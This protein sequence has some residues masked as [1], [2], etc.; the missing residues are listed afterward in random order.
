MALSVFA[1]VELGRGGVVVYWSLLLRH[2]GSYDLWHFAVDKAK[3][4][5]LWGDLCLLDERTA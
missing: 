3:M 4:Q 2:A 1:Q 5:V